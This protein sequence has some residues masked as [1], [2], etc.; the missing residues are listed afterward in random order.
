MDEKIN[1]IMLPVNISVLLLEC[2]S[3]TFALQHGIIYSNK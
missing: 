1:K 2:E 3:S